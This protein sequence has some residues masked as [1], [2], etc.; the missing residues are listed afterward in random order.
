M[1]NINMSQALTEW[2]N[3]GQE[4]IKAENLKGKATIGL[5]ADI[6]LD[7][8]YQ[9]IKD[10][11]RVEADVEITGGELIDFEPL[12][13]MSRFIDVDELTNVKFETLRNQLS[14]RNSKLHIPRM[15]IA[16]S[17]LNVDVFGEHGFDQEMDY[18]VNLLLNDL[19]RRKAKKT[20]TFDGHEILDNKG[21]TRLFLW[22]RGTPANIKVGYDKKEVRQKI[23]A[24]L[25]EEGQTIKKL[26][27]DEFTGGNDDEKEVNEPEVQFR[28]EDDGLDNKSETSPSDSEPKPEPK[29]K[30]KRGLFSSEPEETETEGGF[31]I[32][33]DP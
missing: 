13:A 24:D 29:K 19:I 10:K 16:S 20:R 17:I 7:K 8:D 1:T 5:E 32:E 30:K 9:L 4:T 14:I 21:K 2:N 28:L 22:I 11:L 31:E 25:K 15:S 3:F 12:L 26:F 27:R 18:H 33:F 23:K 6:F